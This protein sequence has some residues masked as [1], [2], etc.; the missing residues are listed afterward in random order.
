MENNENDTEQIS[1]LNPISSQ[2][3]IFPEDNN[4]DMDQPSEVVFDDVENLEYEQEELQEQI[5]SEEDEMLPPVEVNEAKQLN[6]GNI[7]AVI[8]IGVAVILLFILILGGSKKKNSDESELDKAGYKTGYDFSQAQTQQP[9]QIV[10]VDSG[11]SI[12]ENGRVSTDM[13]ELNEIM[14]AGYDDTALRNQYQLPGSSSQK[15]QQS[16]TAPAGI[17][18]V[19]STSSEEK[20]DTRNSNSVRKIEGIKGLSSSNNDVNTIANAMNGN[21]SQ[22]KNPYDKDAY[23]EEQLTRIQKQNNTNAFGSTKS[24]FFSNNAG[25][26]GTGQFLSTNALWD[27]TIIPG[28][29]ITAINTDNPGTVIA[30]VSENV[31]SSLDHSFLLIPEGTVLYGEYNYD[32]SYGQY[33][34]QVGWNLLIRPDGY[35]LNIG[36]FPG[37]NKQGSSGYDG[38]VSNHPF[39][40]LKAMGLIALFSVLE[41]EASIDM[42]NQ[43]N[44]YLQNATA[45]VY[46]QAQELEN[47][48]LDRAL[49]IKPTIKVREG[50]E[51]KL[52]TNTPLELP[53]YKIPEVN[54]K[55]KRTK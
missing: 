33:S 34:I 53:P 37:V 21:Y 50:T 3:V 12:D 45:D 6:V 19:G 38:K 51:I 25:N 18:S 39:Q 55:Y 8:F 42:A 16:G 28:V 31:Y 10:V 17:S 52:I 20:P 22:Y 15:T 14:N 9:P 44:Q 1:D 24:E 49:D 11:F 43:T 36:N 41:T 46:K 26:T 35:R 54:Q 32:V 23:I 7:M 27:G 5:K 30:R 4:S 2:N 13:S 40:T 47:K 48:I 29:L